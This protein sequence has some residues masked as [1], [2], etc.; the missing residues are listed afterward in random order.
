MNEHSPKFERVKMWYDTMRWTKEMVANAVVKG[1]ITA[2]EYQAITGDAYT[3]PETQGTLSDR[4]QTL[5]E[6]V[7]E[8]EGN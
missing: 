2:D 5:E 8:L 3:A 7:S 6:A 4:V 1:R